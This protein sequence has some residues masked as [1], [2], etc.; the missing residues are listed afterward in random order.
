MCYSD[1]KARVHKRRVS[2]PITPLETSAQSKDSEKFSIQTDYQAQTFILHGSAR[3]FAGLLHT[4][5]SNSMLRVKKSVRAPSQ[6][7]PR[8]NL[9]YGQIDFPSLKKTRVTTAQVEGDEQ[10][11]DTI[12]FSATRDPAMKYTYLHSKCP[13]GP[14]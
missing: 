7:K 10:S 5:H 8:F 13:Q 14:P 12:L 3:S 11:S 1:P 2:N 9:M 6:G 4:Q